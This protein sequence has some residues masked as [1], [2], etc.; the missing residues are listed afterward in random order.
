MPEVTEQA[1]LG[2][3]NDLFDSYGDVREVVS[4]SVCFKP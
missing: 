4:A 2:M 1:A 3:R